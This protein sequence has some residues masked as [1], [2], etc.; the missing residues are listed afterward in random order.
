[1][2]TSRRH[3]YQVTET[4]VLGGQRLVASS[5]KFINDAAPPVLASQLRPTQHVPK[6][7]GMLPHQGAPTR[8]A[9]TMAAPNFHQRRDRGWRRGW[10]FRFYNITVPIEG[11]G[12]RPI[13]NRQ[14]TTGMRPPRMLLGL[15][16]NQ[17]SSWQPYQ[18]P[19]GGDQ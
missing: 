1:M 14:G 2:A 7:H 15:L 17:T 6:R 10:P 18:Y 5:A 4:T 13:G 11:A 19:L 9:L 3:G 8:A 12:Y 16:P